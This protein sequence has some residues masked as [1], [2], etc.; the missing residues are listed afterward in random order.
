MLGLSAP[1]IAAAAEDDTRVALLGSDGALVSDRQHSNDFLEAVRQR[2]DVAH[3]KWNHSISK[4]NQY[5]GIFNQDEY[6]PVFKHVVDLFKSNLPSE[7][8]VMALQQLFAE[9]P[10]ELEFYI[11]QITT[12]L[13][14]G[15]FQNSEIL[16]ELM[17][18]LCA[19]SPSMAHKI[20]WFIMSFCLSNAGVGP[21][22]VNTLNHFVSSVE[23]YGIDSARQLLFADT[24][25]VVKFTASNRGEGSNEAKSDKSSSTGDAHTL[26]SVPLSF[27]ISADGQYLAPDQKSKEKSYPIYRTLE[28]IHQ[29]EEGRNFID[30]FSPTFRFWDELVEISREL[31][32]LP[33]E[34][35]SKVLRGKIDTFKHRY[36]PSAAIFAPVGRTHHRCATH[37]NSIFIYMLC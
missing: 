16:K 19:H 35:R 31:C 1:A 2:V 26:I 10:H 18:D 21:G 3:E 17:F 25:D 37:L 12:F 5:V 6:G 15:S 23:K 33:R 8:P 14:Y 36:L 4:F 11:P 28:L 24:T 27:R 22:G 32:A 30:A 29:P 20:R 13:V 9:H 7:E 34:V